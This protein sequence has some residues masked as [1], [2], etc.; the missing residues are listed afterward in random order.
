MEAAAKFLSVSEAKEFLEL[1][2]VTFSEIWIRTLI[3]LGKINSKKVFSSRVIFRSD[4]E[5]IIADRK[6]K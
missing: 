4:L 5:R 1:N 6:G 2:G 3:G